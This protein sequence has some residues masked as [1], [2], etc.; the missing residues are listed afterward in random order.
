[1]SGPYPVSYRSLVPKAEQAGNLLVPVCLAA[2][3]IA[4]GSIRMEPVFMAM[5]QSAA[6]AAALAIDEKTTAQKIDYAKLRERLLKDGQIISWE[7]K[8]HTAAAP[9]PKLDGL[10]LD[11]TDAQQTGE[12]QTGSI[13]ASRRV[14]TGYIHD[15]NENKGACSV[16]WTPEIPAA[17]EY[18][19]TLHFPP[20][21]NR[22]TNVPVTVEAGGKTTTATINERESEGAAVVGKFELAAGKSVTVT[23]TNRGTNGYVVVDGLQLQK[24]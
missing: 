6:T 21:G 1:V 18:E 24:R 2:T 9:L 17:G 22:A 12:W 15:A 23:V 20:N 10:V 5:G 16:R 3:H 4:Y 14:G 19:I 8:P 13:A 7:G 11:D